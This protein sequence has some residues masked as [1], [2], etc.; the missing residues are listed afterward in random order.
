MLP[1]P[2]TAEG[3]DRSTDPETPPTGR[4]VVSSVID[5]FAAVLPLVLSGTSQGGLASVHGTVPLVVNRKSAVA[6]DGRVSATNP[7]RS[8][9]CVRKRVITGTGSRT[10]E[11]SILPH[12][13]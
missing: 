12:P 10:W 6:A 8:I 3:A 1:P 4:P 11:A 5:T 9:W 13:K 7:C 2:S